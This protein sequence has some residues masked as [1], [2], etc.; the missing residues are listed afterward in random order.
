MSITITDPIL[1]AQL[2]QAGSTVDIRDPDGNIIGRFIQE[3]SGTLPSGTNSPF[4]DAQIEE[5]RK[6][7]DSG[8]ALDEFWRLVQR[9]EWRWTI[10]SRGLAQR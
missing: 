4:T 2:I 1:L 10:P 7:P 8:I 5:A 9:G 3:C 6:E